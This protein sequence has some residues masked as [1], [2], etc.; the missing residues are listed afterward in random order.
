MGIVVSIEGADVA[1]LTISQIISTNTA[2][3]KPRKFRLESRVHAFHPSFLADFAA[4]WCGNCKNTFQPPPYKPLAK[5]TRVSWR[6]SSSEICPRCS[7]PP[8]AEGDE[9]PYKWEFMLLL[10]DCHG[11]M[12]PVIVA[13]E[14]ADQLLQLPADKSPPPPPINPTLKYTDYCVV[15]TKTPNSSNKSAIDYSSSG[16]PSKKASPPPHPNQSANPVTTR[17]TSPPR[18]SRT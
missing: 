18:K 4:A 5:L 15:F 9:V 14:D 17:T 2:T 8:N 16:V 6:I 10:E 13:D 11:D 1:P 3:L 12:L 7:L